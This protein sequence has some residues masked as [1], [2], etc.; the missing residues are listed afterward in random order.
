MMYT[1]NLINTHSHIKSKTPS[2]LLCLGSGWLHQIQSYQYI[3]LTPSGKTLFTSIWKSL[4]SLIQAY[5]IS[6]LR[7]SSLAT[8]T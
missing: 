6:N 5:A 7:T 8:G 1:H 4:K 3:I 2:I